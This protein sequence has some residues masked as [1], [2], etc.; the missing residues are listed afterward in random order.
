MNRRTFIKCVGLGMA[1]STLAS[2]PAATQAQSSNPDAS[3]KRLPNVL[4]ICPDQQRWDT[5]AALGNPYVHTPNLDRLV[6]MGT[7]FTMAHCVA[8]VCTPS[9]ANFMTGMYPSA[10][11]GCKNGAAYWP[12]KAPLVSKLLKDVGYTC[13]LAGK[14]HLSS[15]YGET[16]EKRPPDDGYAEFHFSTSPYQ[17]GPANDYLQWL[18]T[19][20][21][22]YD[23]FK[24]LSWSQQGPLH[25]TTWCC[26]R[27][28]D[29]FTRQRNGPWM[30]NINMFH[31]HSPYHIPKGT[32]DTADHDL[33]KLPQPRFRDA[34]LIDKAHWHFKPKAFTPEQVQKMQTEYYATIE[35]VD[36][37]VGRMLDALE[38]TGQLENT[39]IIFTSD[40]G[41]MLCDHGLN[42]K[43]IFYEGSVRVPLIITG[44][45]IKADQQL[46]SLVELTDLAPTLM[47]L[48]G[49]PIPP[50]MQGVS[51]VPALTGQTA[52]MRN[53]IHGQFY[54]GTGPAPGSEDWTES[55]HTMYRDQRYKH[56]V[57]HGYPGGEL[58]DMQQDP[59]EYTNL[60]D[61]PDHRQLRDELL[62]KNFNASARANYPVMPVMQNSDSA[63]DKLKLAPGATFINQPSA[64]D[65]AQWVSIYDDGAGHRIE[66]DH[67]DAAIK[68]YDASGRDVWPTADADLK[69]AMLRTCFDAF[70]FSI[71][72]GPERT[73]RY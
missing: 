63:R 18:T 40:H 53:F 37:N 25:Q 13:A 17:G 28:I 70:V 73:G 60:W 32:L 1:G 52:H 38:R 35:L 43:G 6:R 14:L 47:E 72:P 69:Y 20:G 11:A 59:D 26:D 49:E 22:T 62:L 56:V 51:L 67:S 16:Q 19:K 48:A 64:Q 15:A 23:Q 41:E 45:G 71:D 61:D 21:Y 8:P 66:V 5:I 44:P 3:G 2:W 50:A 24:Q 33:S 57:Y 39:I 10:I 42:G 34:D 12:D 54:A 68:L 29:F 58:F 46:D 27:A 9:R 65:I 4:W 31:P 55:F 30:I 36:Q 7:S